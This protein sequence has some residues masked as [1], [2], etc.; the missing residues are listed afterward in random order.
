MIFDDSILFS[1]LLIFVIDV[2]F[3]IFSVVYFLFSLIVIRQ[4]FLMT[5]TVVTEVG[6]FI[7]FL[8]FIHAAIA[9]GVVILFILII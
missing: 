2:G 8:S 9:L 5:K 4:V 3:T 7:R 6:S 1:P